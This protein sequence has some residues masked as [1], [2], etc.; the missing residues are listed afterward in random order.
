MNQVGPTRGWVGRPKELF[1]RE[2][3]SQN[4]KKPLACWW[5]CTKP[6]DM[7]WWLSIC[8][9]YLHQ[10]LQNDYKPSC[11]PSPKLSARPP[12]SP[13]LGLFRYNQEEKERK[14]YQKQDQAKPKV[15]SCSL[16]VLSANTSKC[17]QKF[18]P[19]PSKDQSKE[20]ERSKQG[21]KEEKGRRKP[22]KQVIFKLIFK[23]QVYHVHVAILR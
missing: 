17:N 23:N 13:P 12:I 3:L 7:Q 22:S 21:R 6:L 11:S 2:N 15:L 10:I 20:I 18:K 8:A 9:S 19:P 5:F 1:W 14:K 16:C 4:I